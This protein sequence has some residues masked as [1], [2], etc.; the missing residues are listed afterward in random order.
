MLKIAIKAASHGPLHWIKIYYRKIQE[1]EIE[2]KKRY[3]E[4]NFL[5]CF[6]DVIDSQ[7]SW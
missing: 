2:A 4:I 5:S 7:S 6:T 3:E 1:T